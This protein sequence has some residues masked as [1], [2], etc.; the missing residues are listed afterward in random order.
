MIAND[1][2]VFEEDEE[3]EEDITYIEY[4]RHLF[5]D[6]FYNYVF[7]VWAR[8]VMISLGSAGSSKSVH[9]AIKSIYRV[10]YKEHN[11]LIV[12]K[13]YN[14]LKDSMF[15]ELKK[16]ITILDLD[17]DFTCTTSP[18]E[19][20]C[21]NGNKI[22]FRG[23]DKVDKIKSLSVEKGVI[24]FV[25]LEE[26]N[27]CDETDLNQIQFRSRGGGER[28]PLEDLYE[29]QDA[30]YSA[31]SPD[32]LYDIKKA[33][34]DKF[35]EPDAQA[36][37]KTVTLL[38]NTVDEQHWIPQRF[39]MKNDKPIFELPNDRDGESIYD[40]EELYIIH[41]THWDNQFMTAEDHYKYEKYRFIDQYYYDVYARGLWGILGDTIFTNFKLARISPEF[42]ANIPKVFYG[43]DFG[44]VDPTAFVKIGVDE[45]K[46]AI[47]ILD[48]AGGS[49]FNT[50]DVI[51]TAYSII[52]DPDDTIWCDSANPMTISD[53][54]VGGLKAKPACKSPGH[55]LHAI[56]VLKTYTI[57]ISENC[58]NFAR[59][60]RSYPW[61][62]DSRG[63]KI[64][65]PQDGDDHYIDAWFYGLNQWLLR[66]KRT[67][68]H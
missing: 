60:I 21:H 33:L 6:K 56:R 27:E 4:P 20:K 47:Y 49:G 52:G 35:V 14:T 24:N 59:E 17:D 36:E 2:L 18:L 26:A 15:T 65:V 39:M 54:G 63:N 57:Y 40:S 64:D 46:A 7:N 31:E 22:L 1:Y 44:I 23:L 9:E 43:C 41:S 48:E 28:L 66:I 50:N 5:N 38:L 68:I 19:I 62:E 3:I 61:Q 11:G 13:V 16:A 51:D 25:V 32:H 67:K 30:M 37:D 12:R 53:M 45:K 42:E 58:V 34:F 29:M 10:R 8:E 55:K